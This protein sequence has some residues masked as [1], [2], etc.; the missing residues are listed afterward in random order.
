M[1]KVLLMVVAAM[2]ATVSARAQHEEG[3]NVIQPRVGITLST[4]T[5]IDDSKMKVDITY[6]VE[7]EHFINDEFSVAGGVLFTD[8]G[9]KITGANESTLK[10]YYAAIPLTANYY[11]L[12]GLALKAGL[13]P[14]FRVKSRMEVDGTKIDFD[15]AVEVLFND[16]DV[17]LNKFDLSIPVGLSYEYNN[18]TLDARYNFGLTKLFSNIDESVRNQVIT[19]TL[20]YKL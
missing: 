1:K 11:V 17:K 9:T 16:D 14:A 5:D 8:Q 19:I 4:L 18:I 7:F 10:L 15:R 20:G 6:G 13:Q 2:L 3:D 12:P